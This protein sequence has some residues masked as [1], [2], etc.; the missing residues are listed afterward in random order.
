MTFDVRD[1]LIADSPPQHIP[2]RTV[3]G[4]SFSDPPS[5]RRSSSLGQ[6]S[7][8]VEPP[9]S[10]EKQRSRQ[11]EGLS[12][13]DDGLIRVEPSDVIDRIDRS[14]GIG[15]EPNR[16]PGD[17]RRLESMRQLRRFVHAMI[18]APATED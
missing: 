7:P 14:I 4:Q 18:A 8:R 1:P 13:E 2:E 17:R 3:F 10:S 5:K 11:M 9:V 16:R 15:V 12:D 6:Q